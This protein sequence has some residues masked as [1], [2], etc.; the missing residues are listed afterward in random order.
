M[1]VLDYGNSSGNSFFFILFQ[2]YIHMIDYILICLFYFVDAFILLIGTSEQETQARL[3]TFSLFLRSLP[4]IF[5][6]FY[7]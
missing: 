3:H 5:Q 2:L 1:L 7:V 4:H 6:L